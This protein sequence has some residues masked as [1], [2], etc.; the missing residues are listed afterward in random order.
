MKVIFCA[1]VLHD[2][3]LYSLHGLKYFFNLPISLF[4]WICRNY[5]VNQFSESST[6]RIEH[7]LTRSQNAEFCEI[8]S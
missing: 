7:S 3:M 5:D 2:K 1:F 4:S 8:E 6:D